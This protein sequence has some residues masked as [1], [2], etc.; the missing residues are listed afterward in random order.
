MTNTQV[1]AVVD[2]ARELFQPKNDTQTSM[3]VLRR[4]SPSEKETAEKVGL[5]YPIYMAVT[6]SIGHDKRGNVTYRRAD[7][8]SDVWE[9]RIDTVAEIDSATG[10]EVLRQVK[11]VE[12]VIDDEL[13]LVANSYRNWLGRNL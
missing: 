9:E 12:R 1:L 4:L 13:P 11:S 3:V 7:D 5:D 6:Q 8:G 10:Q 2:M